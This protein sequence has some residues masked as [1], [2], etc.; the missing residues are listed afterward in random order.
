[1]AERFTVYRGANELLVRNLF[2]ADGVTALPTAS[3][4]VCECE[5]VQAGKVVRTF[6]RGTHP[7]LRASV[8]GT[9]LEL[10]LTSAVTAALKPGP[11]TERYRLG[12]AGAAYTAEPAKNLKKVVV[13]QV[14]LV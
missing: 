9:A 13:D 11:L 2:Q 8:S 10:E 1:M 12:V 6:V 4:V 3:L 5:L 7:E 14:V